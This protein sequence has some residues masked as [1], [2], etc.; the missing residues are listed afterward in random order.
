MGKGVKKNVC[1]CVC[2]CVCSELLYCAS[3][4]NNTINQLQVNINK[5]ISG[6]RV[7]VKRQAIEEHGNNFLKLELKL[8]KCL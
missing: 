6:K 2:V 7:C 1:V 5:K 3:E 8:Y 4:T